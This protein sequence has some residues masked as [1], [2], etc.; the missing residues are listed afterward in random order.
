MHKSGLFH[1]TW[2]PPVP[3]ISYKQQT[4]ICV[5]DVNPVLDTCPA[6]LSSRSVNSFLA[7]EVVPFA[8]QT[9]FFFFNLL[10]FHLS[11]LLLFPEMLVTNTGSC[12][13][14]RCPEVFPLCISITVS[15]SQALR[16]FMNHFESILVQGERQE[17]FYMWVPVFPTPLPY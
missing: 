8:A 12:L 10:Q 16:I 2:W 11:I 13:R 1:L 3:T 14:C 7:L 4:F 17:L 15:K 6:K 5:L 9:P